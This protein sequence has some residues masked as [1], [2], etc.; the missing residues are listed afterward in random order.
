MPAKARRKLRLG[1]PLGW[2]VALLAGAAAV[3]AVLVP[4]LVIGAAAVLAPRLLRKKKRRPAQAQLQPPSARFSPRQALAKAVSYRV[5]ITALDFTSNILVIGELAPAAGLSAFGLVSAPA[6]YFLHEYLWSRLDKDPSEMG[7]TLLEHL[8]ADRRLAKTIT[9]RS[10]AT[11]MDFSANLFVTRNLGQA[12]VLTAFAIVVGPFVYF[13][14][15]KAWDRY[16]AGKNIGEAEP[17]LLY[18]PA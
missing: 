14:H 15:E 13:Y 18:S 12:G 10:I 16:E 17:A 1:G 4:G 5:V 11:V 6:F 9:F 3:E 7:Q 8:P 2:G